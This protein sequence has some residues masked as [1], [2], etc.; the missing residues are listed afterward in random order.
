MNGF[1]MATKLQIPPPRRRVVWRGRLVDALDRDVPRFKLV[2]I[3]A[4]AGYGK[5]TLLSQWAHASRCP[6]AWLSIGAEDDGLDH[7]LRWWRP[8]MAHHGTGTSPPARGPTRSK[9]AVFGPFHHL[10]NM[11]GTRRY[12]DRTGQ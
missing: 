5:T 2:L 4:P 3:S 12:T 11:S 10:P 9:A 8:A 7:F 6:V 1:L